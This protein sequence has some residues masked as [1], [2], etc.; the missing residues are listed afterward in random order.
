MDK[1]YLPICDFDE[2]VYRS[3]PDLASKTH[4]DLIDHF[5]IY[6]IPEGRLFSKIKGREDFL[7]LI[8]PTKGK[9]LEIGPLDSPQLDFK[10]PN[11]YSL[12]VFN[13]DQ[14]IKNY[15]HDPA[16]NK[17][18]IIEPTHVIVNNDYSRIKE[19]FKYIFSSHS[20]EHVPCVLTC[21]RNFSSVLE[22]DGFIY[23]I[24]P[25]KRYCFDHF[26]KETEIYDVLQSYYDKRTR[27]K[28]SDV[29][30]YVTQ[31]TH[32]NCVEHWNGSHGTTTGKAG[33]INHY[34]NLLDRYNTGEYIDAHASFFTPQGF[35]DI[36]STLNDLKLVDLKIH[37]MYHTLRYNLEFYVI[38]KK[39]N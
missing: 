10:S 31:I 37:K 18:K 23:L 30:K 2:A 35:Y 17:D 15:L 8:V 32:N 3:Y 26:K 11:Y 29:L 13:K 4:E 14:L 34:Q 36:I 22:A 9:M 28:L 5:L 1:N 20:I 25:D 19:K 33:L 38:L 12:D 7:K 21:L 16:V 39:N 27:P 6:G 24:I